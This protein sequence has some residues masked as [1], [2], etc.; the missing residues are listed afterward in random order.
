MPAARCFKARDQTQDRGFAAA[1]RS[2][3]NAEL[4]GMN[5]EADIGYGGDLRAALDRE[6]FLHVPDLELYRPGHDPCS[7]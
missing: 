6:A 7:S 1:G 3:Q 5:V 2:Q 4:I